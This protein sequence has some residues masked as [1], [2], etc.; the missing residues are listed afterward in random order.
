MAGL[1][2]DHVLGCAGRGPDGDIQ[3]QRYLDSRDGDDPVRGIGW[4]SSFGGLPRHGGGTPPGETRALFGSEVFRHIH[5]F[6]PLALIPLNPV[7]T[8][9]STSPASENHMR[10]ASSVC[11][12]S[13]TGE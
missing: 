10:T 13:C 5:G 7:P 9:T 11:G 6:L 2:I 8:W 3:L 4:L 12:W 1:M